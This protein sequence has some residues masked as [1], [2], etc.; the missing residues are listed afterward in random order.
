MDILY[1]NSYSRLLLLYTHNGSKDG[2]EFNFYLLC[3][4]SFIEGA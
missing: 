3:I 2:L 4:I 1:F